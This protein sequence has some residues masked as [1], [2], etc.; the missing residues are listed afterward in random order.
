MDFKAALLVDKSFHGLV[1][2][3]ISDMLVTYC[4]NHLQ[5]SEAQDEASLFSL[6][7]NMA[8]QPFQFY[9]AEFWSSFCVR[10]DS[11]PFKLTVS[12]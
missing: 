2:K 5:L 8:R 4:I 6:K 10:K 12:V 3:Y 1:L 9:A 11:S 7:L